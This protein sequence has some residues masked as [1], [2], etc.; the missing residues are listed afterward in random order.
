MNDPADVPDEWWDRLSAFETDFVR[1]FDRAGRRI[2]FRE[3]ATLAYGPNGPDGRRV[4]LA[5]VGGV[6]VSTVW[7]GLDHSVWLP[8]DERPPLIFETM[9]FGPEPF[10]S[11]QRRFSTEAA[12]LAFHDQAVAALKDWAAGRLSADDALRR[13]DL[14]WFE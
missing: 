10:D 3:Y 7:L 4:A 11:Q 5:E 8:G 12:A 2:T 6:R 9:L 1:Y 14:G 13:L